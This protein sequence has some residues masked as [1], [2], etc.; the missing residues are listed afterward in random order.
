[1]DHSRCE[2][3]RGG[4]SS[5]SIASQRRILFTIVLEEHLSRIG[6][7]GETDWPTFFLLYHLAL[8]VVVSLPR[9]VRQWET[10]LGNWGH[11]SVSPWRQLSHSC[12]R[13]AMPVGIRLPGNCFSILDWLRNEM[14]AVLRTR[15]QL[16][17][18]EILHMS[19]VLT[20][21]VEDLFRAAGDLVRVCA[22]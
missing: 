6:G 19:H 16:P 18:A 5:S 10:N 4:K 14:A 11:A 1:M 3:E 15:T 12:C 21:L 17:L 2:E 9:L 13:W 7:P 20:E 22:S 8:R